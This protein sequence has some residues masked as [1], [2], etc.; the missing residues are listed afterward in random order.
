MDSLRQINQTQ[1]H[2]VIC[3]YWPKNSQSAVILVKQVTHTFST[4]SINGDRSH[5][6]FGY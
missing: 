3:N 1:I 4:G 5:Y 2:K 6:A